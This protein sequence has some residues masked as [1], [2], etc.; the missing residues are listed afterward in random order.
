MSATPARLARPVLVFGGSG[1]LGRELLRSLPSIGAVIAP[2]RVDAD[3]TR[4]DT[5]RD[6]IRRVRPS[7]VINAAALTN[8]D[9]AER[10]GDLARAL[11]DVAPGIMAEEARAVDALLVHY[12]TDYVFD[13]TRTTPYDER[14]E[15]NP[16]NVYG[17]TKLAGERNVA[18]V[19]GKHMIIRTSWVYSKLGTGFVA[20]M[21]RRLP[22]VS[23]L[24]VV[25]NQT[26]SPTWSRGLAMA[27]TAI[28]SGLIHDGAPELPDKSRGIYHLAGSGMASRVEITHELIAAVTE[29]SGRPRVP[30][31]IP[32]P[33]ADFDAI[34]K[35]PTF[36]ALANARTA[37]VFDVTLDAWRSELRRMLA[38][39]P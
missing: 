20:S 38:D 3:L 2:P 9:R 18:A 22:E 12:S 26:G 8:V 37:R 4:P 21:L 10:E 34:A 6:V 5:V 28:L 11:N 32:I 23:E 31:V 35:R 7:L 1:Q 33:A 14:A 25:A 17:A 24:R 27:T 39:A 29:S 19:D 36:T 15:P 16:I 30:T 13:G